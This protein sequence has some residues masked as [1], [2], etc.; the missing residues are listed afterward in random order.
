MTTRDMH[1]WKLATSNPIDLPM[2]S[3]PEEMKLESYYSYYTDEANQYHNKLHS[4]IRHKPSML[5]QNKNTQAFTETINIM[6]SQ[7]FLINKIL[8]FLYRE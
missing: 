2:L 7:K 5:Y 4:I 8:V 1:R 3:K 6:N